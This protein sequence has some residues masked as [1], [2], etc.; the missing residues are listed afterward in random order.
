M[1]DYRQ[2]GDV[3]VVRVVLMLPAAYPRQ[4]ADSSAATV[5][6]QNAVL[7]PENFWQNFQF[8]LRQHG[9]VLPS[10]AIHHQ[11]IYSTAT[12]DAPSVLDGATVLLTYD[13]KDVASEEITI[14]VVTP[15]C[16][17]IH[18]AFDLRKLR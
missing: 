18:A 16:K 17:T 9:K 1:G 10:R 14:E 13:S 15:D 8:I 4:E 12:K 5:P 2:R 7:R 6:C 11:P 3:V